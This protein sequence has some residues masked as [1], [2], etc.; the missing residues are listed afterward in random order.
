MDQGAKLG[1]DGD[2]KQQ[3]VEQYTS[4][5]QHFFRNQYELRD[6]LEAEKVKFISK[7]S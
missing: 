3:A 7:Y 2:E 6:Q 4:T 5:N 1:F